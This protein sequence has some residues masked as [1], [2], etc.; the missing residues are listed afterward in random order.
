MSKKQLTGTVIN[1]NMTQT[2]KVQ[3][4]RRWTHPLYQKTIS[5][6]KNFLVDN[7]LKNIKPGDRVIIEE[8]PPI[9]KRKRFK[10]INKLKT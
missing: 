7:Q 4:V 2:A 1:T 6:S 9:S 3:V 5:K 10:I 8:C